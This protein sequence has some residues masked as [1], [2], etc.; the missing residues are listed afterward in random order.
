MK[1]VKQLSIIIFLLIPSILN[2]ADTTKVRSGKA[3]FSVK[4]SYLDAMTI[5]GENNSQVDLTDDVGF[6]FEFGYNYSEHLNISLELSYN[7]PGY[8]AT[9]ITDEANSREIISRNILDIWNSQLNATYN[10]FPTEFTPFVSAGLGWSYMDSRVATGQ[11]EEF[12]V[13]DPWYGYICGGVQDTYDVYNFSYNAK[14]GLRW[15][16]N[17]GLFL[18]ADYGTY[19]YDFDYSK[20]MDS[21]IIQLQIG[22]KY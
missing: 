3:E 10:F 2:A 21:N 16:I 5:E 13:W 8:T 18:I 1:L 15:D 7:Q 4:V 14:V 17:D 22:M 9:V 11:Y 19:W 6:A 20:T 12:C